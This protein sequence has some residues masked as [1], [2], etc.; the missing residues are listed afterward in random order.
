MPFIGSPA[1]A[2]DLAA[3]A[4]YTRERVEDEVMDDGDMT[5]DEANVTIAQPVQVLAI[6]AT[7][8]TLVRWVR[9]AIDGDDNWATV[10]F[11]S[12]P[13]VAL[14]EDLGEVGRMMDTEFYS[15]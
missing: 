11:P 15:K 2:A 12:T 13:L 1:F 7:P 3:I 4:E 5:A 10:D 9:L 6:Q 8:Q 14:A